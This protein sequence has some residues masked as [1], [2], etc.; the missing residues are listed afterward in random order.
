[1]GKEDSNVFVTKE[2]SILYRCSPPWRRDSLSKNW[3]VITAYVVTVPTCQF[4]LLW[5]C[6]VVI[7]SVHGLP[8]ISHEWCAVALIELRWAM[9]IAYLTIRTLSLHASLEPHDIDTFTSGWALLKL[10][11]Q[12][13]TN[14]PGS[15]LLFIFTLPHSTT[16][17]LVDQGES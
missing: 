1:M 7:T 13:I 4:S 15:L 11:L 8:L 14:S 12:S 5:L 9:R 2:G 3:D 16:K 6:C 17:A 10:F